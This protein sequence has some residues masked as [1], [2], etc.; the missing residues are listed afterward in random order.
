MDRVPRHIQQVF[1]GRKK[2]PTQNAM[3]AVN[4]DLLFTYVLADWEGSTHDATVLADAI[5]RDDGFTLPQ[6]NCTNHK[7]IWSIH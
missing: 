6:R 7:L 5:E 2:D 4:C 3:V 1:R